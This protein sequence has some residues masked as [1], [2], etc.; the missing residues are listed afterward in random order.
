MF[1]RSSITSHISANHSYILLKLLF[2]FSDAHVS[3]CYKCA[4]FVK[5]TPTNIKI[6][7]TAHVFPQSYATISAKPHG[8]HIMM[9]L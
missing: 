2:A 8:C 9:E 1:T 6:H 7:M 4:I 3:S 5:Q